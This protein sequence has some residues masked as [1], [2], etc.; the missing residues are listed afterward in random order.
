MRNATVRHKGHQEKKKR[1][2]GEE[3]KMKTKEKR[4]TLGNI[5]TRNVNKSKIWQNEMKNDRVRQQ[6]HQERMEKK[7]RKLQTKKKGRHQKTQN[8]KRK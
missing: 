1:K 6:E 3:L 8:N 5:Q 2:K 4:K 7:R